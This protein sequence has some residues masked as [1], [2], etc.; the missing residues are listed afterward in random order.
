MCKL[1]KK[2]DL[3]LDPDSIPVPELKSDYGSGSEHANNFGSGQIGIYTLLA[4]IGK[5]V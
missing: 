1:E 5:S 2:T 3:D 4:Q